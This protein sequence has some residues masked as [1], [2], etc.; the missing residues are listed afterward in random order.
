[1]GEARDLL[2]PGT[3]KPGAAFRPVNQSLHTAQLQGALGLR[4]HHRQL[5]GRIKISW[6]PSGSRCP[7]VCL[8]TLDQPASPPEPPKS[9]THDLLSVQLF[10][11]SCSTGKA[12]VSARGRRDV[13]AIHRAGDCSAAGSALGWGVLGGWRCVG[14]LRPERRGLSLTGGKGA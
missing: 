10:V 2:I 9:R 12:L 14:Q 7:H 3:I 11:A 1:M 13:G 8:M 6:I 5:H 4:R